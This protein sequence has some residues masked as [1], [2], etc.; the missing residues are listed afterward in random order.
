MAFFFQLLNDGLDVLT[1]PSG[2]GGTQILVCKAI[3]TRSEYAVEGVH[4]DL[5]SVLHRIME[6]FLFHLL[7]LASEFNLRL[8]F[9]ALTHQIFK[10]GWNQAFAMFCAPE[11]GFRW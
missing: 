10:Q 5:D 1:R 3:E 7:I 9:I 4:H 6:L 11:D 2:D 8:V